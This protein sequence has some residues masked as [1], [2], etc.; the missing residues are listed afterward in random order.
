MENIKW[1]IVFFM[2]LLGNEVFSWLCL[3]ALAALGIAKFVKMVQ[4][5]ER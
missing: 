3:L 2:F 5:A 1:V 4:E